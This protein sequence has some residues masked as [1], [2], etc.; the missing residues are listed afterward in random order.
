M[1]QNQQLAIMNSEN[2]MEDRRLDR[3]DRKEER[4]LTRQ[5][6]RI[7]MIMRSLSS[8]GRAFSL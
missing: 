3:E 7:E 5:Q 8:L 1:Q 6:M 4:A 2:R